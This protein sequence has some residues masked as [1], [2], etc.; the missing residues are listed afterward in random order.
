M[1]APTSISTPCI[2]VCI[3]DGKNGLCVGC[4]RTLAEIAGWGGMDEERRRAVMADLPERLS[5]PSER[6]GQ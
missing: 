6:H 1:S 5:K 4:G 3:V 2:K